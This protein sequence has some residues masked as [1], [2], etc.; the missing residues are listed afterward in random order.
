M[1]PQ[2]LA[3]LPWHPELRFRRSGDVLRRDHTCDPIFLLQSRHYTWSECSP[4]TWNPDREVMLDDEDN[5]ISCEDGVEMGYATVH[6]DVVGV[7]LTRADAEQWGNGRA[8]RYP[9]GWRVYCIS[10]EGDLTTVLGF[11]TMGGAYR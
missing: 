8:Y 11:A 4:C 3:D 9:N 6:W 1:K 10:A 7:F 2:L 5:E